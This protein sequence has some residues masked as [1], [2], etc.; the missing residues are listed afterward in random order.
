VY[1]GCYCGA[2][3]AV[4]ISKTSGSAAAACESKAAAACARGCANFPGRVAQDGKTTVDGTIS[5]RC[6]SGT[7]KTFIP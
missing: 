1:D 2:Q 6:S 3:P 4:G 7:C 5:V